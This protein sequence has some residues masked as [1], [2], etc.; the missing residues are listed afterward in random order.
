MTQQAS[1]QP[2]AANGQYPLSYTQEWFCS[3]DEGDDNGAFGKRFH[4]VTGLRITGRV[5]IPALQ[6][7]LDDVV[8]RHELLRTVVIRDADPPYQQ[9][10]P[11]CQVPLEVRDL[12]ASDQPRDLIAEEMIIEAERSSISPRQVPVMRA[13]LSRFDDNDS[14]LVLLTHH[15]ATDAWSVNV[16]TRDLA[17]FYDAR[18]HHH[19]V[20][21]PPVTQYR[22]FAQWQKSGSAA[23]PDEVRTYWQDKLRGA[24]A[25]VIPNDRPRPAVYSRPMSGYNYVVGPGEIAPV[26]TF[27]HQMRCSMF[28][29]MLAAF[30]V[31]AHEVTG[32]ADPAFRAL[33]FGRNEPA[34]HNTLGLFL[35]MVP[36]RTDIS[37]CASF[38]EIVASTKDTCIDAY[39]NEVPIAVIEQEVPD[40]MALAAEPGNSEII[41]GMWQQQ[42]EAEN[43]LPIA[44]GA[45]TIYKRKLPSHETS[46]HPR[47]MVWNMAAGEAGLAGNVNYNLDEFDEQKVT[48][49]TARYHQILS[50][51]VS[52]PDQPWRELISSS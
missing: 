12:P 33:T 13:T 9:V 30:E 38:R 32:R 40:F 10:Y 31:F 42:P 15:S 19:P 44:D 50:R 20:D 1:S 11:P 41:V 22:E 51:L 17:A 27:T 8:E 52:Q 14:V 21:L 45:L 49:W 39:S 47:G 7:A 5:D 25:L 18:T 23:V 34:F 37:Q 48:G 2:G 29:V 26:V 35:N 6:G 46:D 36:F 43:V 16:V 28:M 24:R 4:L 3:L